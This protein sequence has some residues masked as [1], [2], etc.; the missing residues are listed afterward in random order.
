MSDNCS[1]CTRGNICDYFCYDCEKHYCT[2]CIEKHNRHHVPEDSECN[3]CYDDLSGITYWKRHFK[4]SE[5]NQ[6]TCSNCIGK[7]IMDNV[8]NNII[9]PNCNYQL[10]VYD[11]HGVLDN[12]IKNYFKKLNEFTLMIERETDYQ[13]SDFLLL[14][15]IY[16]KFIGDRYGVLRDVCRKYG[17]P[18]KLNDSENFM[19]VLLFYHHFRNIRSY[20]FNSIFKIMIGTATKSDLFN[21]LILIPQSRNNYS[22]FN[23][24]AFVIKS[25]R[26]GYD[27]LSLENSVRRI[28]GPYKIDDN[29]NII[30]GGQPTVTIDGESTKMTNGDEQSKMTNGGGQS[31]VI[32]DD[33]STKMESDGYQLLYNKFGK[34]IVNKEGDHLMLTK[35]GDVT[36]KP[37]VY[38]DYIEDALKYSNSTVVE[39]EKKV[40]V[41]KYKCQLCP[42]LLNNQYKCELCET[43]FC[44]KCFEKYDSKHECKESDIENIKLIKKETKPCPKCYERIFRISGCAQMFCTSCHISFDWNTGAIVRQ[45]FHNP[46]RADWLQQNRGIVEVFDGVCGLTFPIKSKYYDYLQMMQEINEL[47]ARDSERVYIDKRRH[48]RLKFLTNLITE[49]EYHKAFVSLENGNRYRL[50]VTTILQQYHD[51]LQDLLYTAKIRETDDFL[52]LIQYAEKS[53]NELLTKISKDMFNRNRVTIDIVENASYNRG[54]DRI[55][56]IAAHGWRY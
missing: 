54:F 19:L 17:L 25:T 13:H 21:K 43:K 52:P 46:H 16:G 40:E 49:K 4:C 39:I 55:S 27:K 23:L 42:G 6:W 18:V 12:R 47:L 26:L 3:I 28:L 32:I 51:I 24:F 11:I 7:H 37:E 2:S 33:E 15:N 14:M 35:Y 29:G 48:L 38:V 30:G 50:A 8:G 10:S 53:T 44:G 41:F 45:N 22:I 56:T 9:C 20:S 1:F 36:V 34:P 31:T 5:C